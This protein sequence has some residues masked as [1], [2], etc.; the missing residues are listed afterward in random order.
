MASMRRASSQRL[1][2]EHTNGPSLGQVQQALREGSF[3]KYLLDRR[4]NSTAGQ[5][6]N[7]RQ[8]WLGRTP[9]RTNLTSE[10]EDRDLP[11]TKHEFS[12]S[13]LANRARRIMS[14]KLDRHDKIPELK[15]MFARM[16]RDF[17]GTYLVFN[18]PVRFRSFCLP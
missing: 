7:Q 10:E 9:T 16:D 18:F 12:V 1:S 13:L 2:K 4:E 5:S 17:D 11:R 15:A 3:A 8:R 14:Q 6:E